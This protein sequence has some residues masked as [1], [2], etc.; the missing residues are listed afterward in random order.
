[1]PYQGGLG[2]FLG[3]SLDIIHWYSQKMLCYHQNLIVV[4]SIRLPGLC[5][6]RSKMSKTFLPGHKLWGYKCLRGIDPDKIHALLPVHV[7]SNI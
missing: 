4:G 7:P 1:M 3:I 2:S 5:F 6:K